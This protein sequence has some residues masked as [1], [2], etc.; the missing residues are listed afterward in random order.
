MILRKKKKEVNLEGNVRVKLWKY[1]PGAD[2]PDSDR[3]VYLLF[4]PK[5]IDFFGFLRKELR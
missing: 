5:K 4:N 3:V 2:Y 1:I